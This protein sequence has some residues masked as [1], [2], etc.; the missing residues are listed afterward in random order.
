MGHPEV[1]KWLPHR[2]RMVLLD[3]VV[4]AGENGAVAKV[5]I[6]QD[7]E[8]CVDG[9][10]PAWVGIEY[11]AQTMAAYSGGIAMGKDEEVSIAFLL[12]ARRYNSTVS[13]YKIG[14]ELTIRV[15][16]AMFHDAISN[17]DCVIELNSEEVAT[18]GL[19]AYKPDKEMLEGF[20]K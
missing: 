14:D 4:E 15:K 10:V 12:G 13:H 17:F 9:K 5:N 6:S 19:T 8:F 20:K 3:E 16:P 2:E 7:T 18:A 1:E 11:M